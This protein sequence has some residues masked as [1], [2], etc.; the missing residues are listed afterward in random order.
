MEIENFV[1]DWNS[2]Y[3]IRETGFVNFFFFFITQHFLTAFL[4]TIKSVLYFNRKCYYKWVRTVKNHEPVQPE[5]YYKL[6]HFD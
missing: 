5:I 3:V 1:V 6:L 4:Y 2:F